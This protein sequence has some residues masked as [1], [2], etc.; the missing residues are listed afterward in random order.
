MDF[1]LS[2]YQQDLIRN[3]ENFARKEMAPLAYELDRDSKFS[4]ELWGKMGELGLP[5]LTIPEQYGGSGMGALDSCLCLQGLGRGGGDTGT[6][7]SLGAHITIANMPIVLFGTEAQKQKYL[8][9]MATGEWIGGMGLTEPGA[10]SDAGALQTRA[11]RRGDHYVLNGTK[12]FITNGPTGTV[13]IVMARTDKNSKGSRGVSA[14]IVEKDFPGFAVG[15]KLEK[16][17]NRASPTSEL[18]FEDCL[19]PVGNIIASEGEGFTKVGQGALEWE[20]VVQMGFWLGTM[21]YSLELSIE[22][23]RQ[24]VQFKKPI[25]EFQAI[26]HKLAMMKLDIDATALLV[27]R[28]AY[29]KDLNRW[30]D[31]EASI[32]KLYLSQAIMRNVT[33]AVQI[34]GGYGLMKEYAVE[35]NFRDA[36]LTEVG[37]GTSEIQKDIIARNILKK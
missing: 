5:G 21:E 36:K 11:E 8:P 19:V 3:M 27:Y 2:D 37:G 13:F 4:M 7:L 26:R 20:R 17:G 34:H 31:T 15:K 6:N 33:E 32:A 24:R 12:M 35:R 22:Y 29:L 14:F 23:S 30:S 18:I 9:R 1:S 10:G 25:C 28:A 16:M